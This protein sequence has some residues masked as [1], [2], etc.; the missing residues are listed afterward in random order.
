MYLIILFIEFLFIF[1]D[2]SEDSIDLESE[3]LNFEIESSEIV[4]YDLARYY[5]DKNGRKRDRLQEMGTKDGV[6]NKWIRRFDTVFLYFSK[7]ILV[8][9]ILL[10][11]VAFFYV[12]YTYLKHY[13]EKKR[14]KDASRRI[15][16]SVHIIREDGELSDDE[17]IRKGMRYGSL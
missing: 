2:S 11:F 3:L 5:I 8:I 14:M 7:G 6:T 12:G 17:K 9:A 4:D 13:R 10:A 15:L 1:A 16:E